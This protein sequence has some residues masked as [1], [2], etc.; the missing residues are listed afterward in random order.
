MYLEL[1]KIDLR[2]DSVCRGDIRLGYIQQEFEGVIAEI[3][4]AV[5]AEEDF[6]GIA[7]GCLEDDIWYRYTDLPRDIRDRR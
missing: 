1:L 7:V 4:D 2:A 5:L 3:H 6:L